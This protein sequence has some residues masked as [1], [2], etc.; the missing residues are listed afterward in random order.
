MRNADNIS[1]NASISLVLYTTERKINKLL[2]ERIVTAFG[3]YSLNNR[4]ERI[5]A[6]TKQINM[7][8][9]LRPVRIF[10]AVK[11]TW[12][13]IEYLENCFVYR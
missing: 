7:S 10:A 5:F 1:Q 12:W 4:L 6:G 9:Y 8:A 3:H 11:Y 13:P 2:T